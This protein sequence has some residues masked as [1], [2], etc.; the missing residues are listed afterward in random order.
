MQTERGRWFLE[1]YAKRNRS[2]DTHL[3]LAAIE[4]IETVVC[5]ER[6]RQAQQGFRSDLLEM[7]KAINRTRAEVAEIGSDAA[8][9]L[10]STQPDGEASPVPRLP[11][12]GD[13]FA[14]AERIRDVT[15]AMRGH[16]FDPSTCD[17]LEELAASIL[18]ATSL[19]DPADHRASKLVEVLQ[20]LE[21]RIDTLLLSSAD[22]NTAGPEP[23][24]EPEHDAFEPAR[25]GEKG[26]GNGF[27]RPFVTKDAAAASTAR[28]LS[29]PTEPH[30]YPV[31]ALDDLEG[32]SA[33]AS[34]ALA[35]E[36]PQPEVSLASPPGAR[37]QDLASA[38]IDHRN[39]PLP[40]SGAPTAEVAP[41][42]PPDTDAHNAPE[43]PISTPDHEVAGQI[44]GDATPPS[45]QGL[46]AEPTPVVLPLP[47][48]A[49]ERSQPPHPGADN[50][51]E[52]SIST[53]N[54]EAG[55]QIAGD[56]VPSDQGLPSGVE[57]TPAVSPLPSPA[58]DKAEFAADAEPAVELS[59]KALLVPGAG[60]ETSQVPELGT[61]PAQSQ[62]ERGPTR[63]PQNTFR[64]A[65][66]PTV[67]LPGQLMPRSSAAQAAAALRE[68][69]A[70]ARLPDIDLRSGANAAPAPGV[71]AAATM[72][73]RGIVGS[74]ESA[75]P[76]KTDGADSSDVLET[77]KPTG[78]DAAP[79][80]AARVEPTL[81]LT[82][83]PLAAAVPAEPT[84]PMPR[85]LLGDPLATLKAMSDNELIALFS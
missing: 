25:T 52:R 31:G 76:S 19:R 54:H 57:P 33:A 6:N 49:A 8:S 18:S 50:A 64:G 61:D 1:E 12:S 35:V 46:R 20:Y 28:P 10:E 24:G 81:S 40:G 26:P 62:D 82:A 22:G 67:E 60:P 16:G 47:S 36:A 43:Q 11:Q 70:R 77:A 44:A 74:L 5:A 55:G 85:P 9:R 63:T 80:S 3:L 56:A 75:R 51:P 29:P 4:R 38:A 30:G 83:P 37:A 58:G 79:D 13:I 42:H 32:Y 59:P 84:A 65:L 48:P 73:A 7:A 66:L 39:V 71:P 68:A 2:A 45:D 41:G 69:G 15:W 53:R 23:A 78:S 14:A 34:P 72:P 27:A 17:Q 21:R